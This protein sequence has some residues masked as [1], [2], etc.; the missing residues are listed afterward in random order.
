MRDWTLPAA[1]AIGIAALLLVFAGI[2]EASG[3]L[4]PGGL[5]AS[6]LLVLVAASLVFVAH[7][8]R[9]DIDAHARELERLGRLYASL[10]HINQ[11]VLRA[12]T[13]DEL[14]SK[15]C[16]ALVDHGGF[17]LAWISW[18][19]GATQS[20]VPAAH[21]GDTDGF[22][23]EIRIRIDDVHER[24]GPSATAFREGRPNVSNDLMND[25]DARPWLEPFRR[26]G[27]RASAAIPIRQLG[28][29]RGTLS[30]YATQPHVFQDKEVALLEES[31][32]DL[33]FGLDNLAREFEQR[34]TAE[35]AER[36]RGFSA[37]LVESVPGVLY[38]YDQHG[39]FLRWN[40][41]FERV[42]GYSGEEL[43][44]IHP[45]D[46]FAGDD[47]THV[48]ERIAEVFATGHSS[49]EAS[50]VSRDGTC[51]PY[52]FTGTRITV[53]GAPCLVGVGID[54]S[55]RV[56]AQAALRDSEQRFHA[57]MD[58]SPAIAW[59]T[60]AEG[61]HLYMNRAWNAAFG[62]DRDEWIGKTAFDLVPE[63]VARRIRES[64]AEVLRRDDTVEIIDDLVFVQ[65]R[66]LYWNCFKFPFRN[67]AGERLIGGIAIDVTARREAEQQ[68]ALAETR[69]RETN[70][71]LERTVAERTRELQAAL[72]G[73]EAADRTKSAFLATMSHELRTPLNSILG[74][75]GII[76]QGLAGP[77]ND[78][79]IKQLGMVRNSA[80]HLLELIGD[81]LDIS[82]IEAGQLEVRAEPFD[83]R[84]SLDRVTSSVKPMLEKKGL[85]LVI[86]VDPAIDEMVSD[87]RRVEQVLLN[88]VN[89]AV[90]F[91]DRGR[92]SVTA[93]LPDPGGDASDPTTTAP[94]VR[95]DVSD[96]GIG[97]AP[98]DLP[99][100]FA[101]FHQID[102]GLTRLHE[103][104]GLGLAICRRLTDLLG[105][106][107]S[108]QSEP[109]RGSTFT[110]LLPLHLEGT[111]S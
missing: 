83:L 110:V 79:Q 22:L 59:I 64:D 17:R 67:A 3:V 96:T 52:F 97:I 69:L 29:V 60:D 32:L 18:Y 15:V 62:L 35:D 55:D 71:G 12:P 48:G 23:D 65:G 1:A 70:D 45:L 7:R 30:V 75:T 87:R 78:E 99:S 76:L 88:L 14:L 20:L 72:L 80:R 82:K 91:T 11:A 50:L 111:P 21:A 98:G 43:A 28:I 61:R 66:E 8:A 26:R 31:A 53:D 56:D 68:R 4:V 13:R 93:R 10:S 86:D 25:P 92:V 16:R 94:M 74:F 77:L 106:T 89:N 38:L 34:R 19:D 41:E 84:T 58:A 5:I 40:S 51:T 104:T 108:V 24:K 107:I 47:R 57:F 95:I 102:T 54:V 105:G 73:A 2:A 90:K 9:R 6:G 36:E 42:T 103:G 49:V 46:L 63:A 101:P 81:V 39:H 100:L 44:T 109:G 37:S 27:I 33:S 85:A